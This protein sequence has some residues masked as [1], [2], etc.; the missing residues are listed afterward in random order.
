M[1]EKSPEV[2]QQ[3]FFC[4]RFLQ[5]PA[6][7][8]DHENLTL[9]NNNPSSNQQHNNSLATYPGQHRYNDDPIRRTNHSKEVNLHQSRRKSNPIG[10]DSDDLADSLSSSLS[11]AEEV[12]ERAKTRKDRLWTT[13]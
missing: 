13:K 4:K 3:I 8:S 7:Q 11:L 12:L 2:F 1:F 10:G 6:D 5:D 9:N